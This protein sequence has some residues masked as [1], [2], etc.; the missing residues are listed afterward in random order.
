ASGLVKSH[1]RGSQGL[2][3]FLFTSA[4]RG[5]ERVPSPLRVVA[6]VSSEMSSANHGTSEHIG[7]EIHSGPP[8]QCNCHTAVE[9][10]LDATRSRSSSSAPTSDTSSSSRK[11]SCQ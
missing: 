7:V 6:I 9:C 11:S 8:P 4:A 2:L 5:G 1:A 10:S 3:L